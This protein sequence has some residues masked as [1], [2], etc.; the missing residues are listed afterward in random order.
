MASNSNGTLIDCLPAIYHA[1]D[2]LREVLSVFEVLLFGSDGQ[3]VSRERPRM[4][5][6]ATSPLAERIAMI[7]SLFDACDTPGEFLPWLGQWVAFVDLDGLSERRKRQLLAEIVPLYSKKGTKAYLERLLKLFM[8][9]NATAEI[10]DEDVPG[11]VVGTARIGIS[12][13]LEHDRAFWFRVTIQSPEIGGPEETVY[14][15]RWEEQIRRVIELAKPAH[16]LYDLDWRPVKK[17]D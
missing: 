5:L 1:S 16:T 2:D 14:R 3:E 10:D 15:S 4:S 9:G 8:P 12:S 6:T 11:F 7:A 17:N 13:W